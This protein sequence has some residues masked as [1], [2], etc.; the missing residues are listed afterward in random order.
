MPEMRGVGAIGGARKLRAKCGVRDRRGNDLQPVGGAS[1]QMQI[2]RG[3]ACIAAGHTG[4]VQRVQHSVQA[5]GVAGVLRWQ[6]DGGEDLR[7]VWHS[8]IN[9][10]RMEGS[11]SGAQG[12][13]D[14][15][16]VKRGDEFRGGDWESAWVGRFVGDATA[17]CWQ[18][19]VFV[20]AGQAQNDS[21]CRA[22]NWGAILF[23][24][25]P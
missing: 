6:G 15:S 21:L 10:V 12:I 17:V 4:A 25:F 24:R 5:E 23:S 19:R 1:V 2:V 3:N 11:I 9:G 16:A 13:A 22:M 8:G 14:G 20:S 7:E 18:I